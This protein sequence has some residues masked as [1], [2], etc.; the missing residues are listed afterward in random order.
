MAALARLRAVAAGS[1]VR[2]SFCLAEGEIRPP[3]C[4]S[5]SSSCR[6]LTR[7]EGVLECAFGRYQRVRG[8]A[9]VRPRPGPDP[10][11]RRE[12]LLQVTRGLPARPGAA[13]SGRAAGSPRPR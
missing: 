7:G 10:L 5:C 1:A 6:P 12:Y 2:D 8:L 11:S 13:G 4:T 3:G 9:P